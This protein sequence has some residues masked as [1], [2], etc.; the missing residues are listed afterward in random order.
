MNL[1][2]RRH[3]RDGSRIQH[4]LWDCALLRQSDL[5]VQPFQK[6][7]VRFRNRL[8]LHEKG[9]PYARGIPYSEISCDRVSGYDF[10]KGKESIAV[11]KKTN[12]SAFPAKLTLEGAAEAVAGSSSNPKQIRAALI[13]QSI[14]RK[15]MATPKKVMSRFALR[16]NMQPHLLM[17]RCHTEIAPFGCWIKENIAQRF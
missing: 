6:R 1:L 4:L 2:L 5:Y 16:E 10:R 7:S 13:R 3:A 15:S 12:R 8:R 11:L 9:G 14:R 17:P